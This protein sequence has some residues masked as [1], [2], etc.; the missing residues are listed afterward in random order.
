MLQR[1]PRGMGYD[2]S[3]IMF[4]PDGR[5][6]QVEYAREAM[7]KGTPS[8]GVRARNGLIL[9]GLRQERPLLVSSKKI[10]VVD[11]HLGLVFSGYSA[12]GKALISFA[13]ERAQTHRFIYDEPIDVRLLTKEVSEHMH[14]FSQYGGARPY[15]CGLI[16]GGMDVA[17]PG[18]AYLDPGGTTMELLAGVIGSQ[19]EKGERILEEYA[20]NNEMQDLEMESAIKLGFKALLESAETVPK[21]SEIELGIIREGKTFRTVTAKKDPEILSFYK[22][23]T[24]EKKEEEGE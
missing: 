13:R 20:K 15:G 4:S 8:V 10:F 23:L 1:M 19:K 5:I 24:T 6:I 12:D 16:I 9:L 18:L 14:M 17:G 21:P 22:E 3:T 7:R 2:R 11:D